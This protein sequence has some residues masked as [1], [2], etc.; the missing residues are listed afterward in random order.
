[1]QRD[2]DAAAA[3]AA[4]AGGARYAPDGSLIVGPVDNE[5]TMGGEDGTSL[6][7]SDSGSE[8]VSGNG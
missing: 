1:M 8:Q 4:Q 3:E 5:T 2:M 6:G 7:L